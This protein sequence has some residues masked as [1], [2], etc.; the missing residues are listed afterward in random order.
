MEA[1]TIKS[2]IN[3]E[4]KHVTFKYDATRMTMTFSE[5]EN[6]KKTYSGGDIYICLAMIRSDFPP[7]NIFM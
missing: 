1:K 4:E 3:N 5:A 7:Y 2:I 6:F